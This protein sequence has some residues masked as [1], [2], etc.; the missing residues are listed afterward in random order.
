MCSTDDALARL[1]RSV[2][3]LRREWYAAGRGEEFEE[4]VDRYKADGMWPFGD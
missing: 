4:L 2:E 1:R 3:S